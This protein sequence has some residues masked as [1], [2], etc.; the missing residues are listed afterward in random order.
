MDIVAAD[1]STAENGGPRDQLLRRNEAGVIQI[2]G[3]ENLNV[4]TAT[5]NPLLSTR[6][7][8]AIRFNACGTV[9][10]IL[11]MK[12]YG[13]GWFSGYFAGLV[14]ARLGIPFRRVR[15]YYSAAV[16]AVRF[17]EART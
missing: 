8:W 13:R 16:P 15:I 7:K 11:G 5:T 1:A 4:E 17:A 10:A 12:D 3:I 9:T 6:R 2:A 14:A